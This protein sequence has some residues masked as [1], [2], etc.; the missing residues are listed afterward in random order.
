MGFHHVAI[1]TRDTKATHEFYTEAMGFEL[2]KVVAGPT[3]EGGWSKH[4]FYETGHHELIAFWELHDESIDPDFSPAIAKG[5]GLPIWTNH[6]AFAAADLDDL[7]ARRDRWLAQG[8]DVMEADH[9][10]CHSVYT[11]DPN[12]ILVEFCVNVREFTDQDREEAEERLRDPKP[13]FDAPAK[14]KFH[15]A[16][17]DAS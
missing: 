3:P 13:P 2:A 16:E 7:A 8:H 1:A 12:G 14:V 15:R 9:D 5:L 6:I 10:W 4:F 11:E 17:R